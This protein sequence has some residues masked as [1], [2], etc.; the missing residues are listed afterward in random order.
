MGPHAAKTPTAA[1]QPVRPVVFL[2]FFHPWSAEVTP[3]GKTIIDQAAAKIK[4]TGP[5]TVT[6]AGYTADV[7]SPDQDSAVAE[8]RVAA[9]RDALIADG[10]DPKLFLKIPLG[11]PDDTAGKTGDRRIEIRLSYG[12]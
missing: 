10:I 3:V 12:G 9:V 4:E 7:G 11:P 1:S 5:S 6:I 8:N 2:L